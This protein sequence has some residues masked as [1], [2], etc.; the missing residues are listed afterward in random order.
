V[1]AKFFNSP[2]GGIDPRSLIIIAQFFN[3]PTGKIDP[4]S[5]KLP[6]AWTTPATSQQFDAKAPD[7]KSVGQHGKYGNKKDITNIPK[8]SNDAEYAIRRLRKDQE[9][10]KLQPHG[11]DRSNLY[12]DKGDIQHAP[13]GTSAAAALRRLRKD[14]PD[15]HARMLAGEHMGRT[16][17]RAASGHATRTDLE[18]R[19]STYSG[20]INKTHR[21][22][23]TAKAPVASAQRRAIAVPIAI[24]IASYA[25]RGAVF[26]HPKAGGE[27]RKIHNPLRVAARRSEKI[28]SLFAA[29]LV[30]IFFYA[31]LRVLRNRR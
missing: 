30:G 1:I 26:G 17:R 20:R 19:I 7:L 25:L 16:L 3:L 15:I 12:N 2:I 4:R 29:F 18:S 13:S 28:Y 27:G 23:P 22:E 24:S 31:A 6:V 10:K 14:R 21:N 11:G 8:P 5:E 9:A